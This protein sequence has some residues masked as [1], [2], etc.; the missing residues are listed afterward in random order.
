MNM[1]RIIL[2]SVAFLA[3]PYFFTLPNKRYDF[4]ISAAFW[5]VSL[6]VA[7]FRNVRPT[8]KNNFQHYTPIHAYA[9]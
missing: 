3:L 9:L 1:L 7:V 4:H 2:I 6:H 5:V 8:I